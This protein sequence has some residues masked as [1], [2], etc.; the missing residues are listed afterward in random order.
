MFKNIRVLNI[1]GLKEAELLNLG[2]INVIC[3]KNNSGKST[4]LEGIDTHR[5]QGKTFEEK[6]IIEF[7]RMTVNSLGFGKEQLNFSDGYFTFL[8]S[9]LLSTRI[10][11]KNDNDEVEF[12]NSFKSAIDGSMRATDVFNS[13]VATNAYREFLHNHD[14][15][16]LLPPKGIF[17]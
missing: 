17:R 9:F 7:H 13:S 8:K 14:S 3:G 10:W 12:V 5:I 15:S 1:K 2:K 16:I 6:D 11:Y 4:L